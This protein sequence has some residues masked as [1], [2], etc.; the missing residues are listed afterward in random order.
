[1]DVAS[2]S[3]DSF[4]SLEV[5]TLTLAFGRGF[6][7]LVRVHTSS[8]AATHGFLQTVVAV[9]AYNARSANSK[10]VFLSTNLSSHGPSR[11]FTSLMGILPSV[12]ATTSSLNEP[13]SNAVSEGQASLESLVNS[14]LRRRRSQTSSYRRA[15]F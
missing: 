1:M 10:C 6:S 12:P 4:T 5:C 3:T 2:G 8:S 11:Y 15:A 9:V 7:S 13:M 14:H